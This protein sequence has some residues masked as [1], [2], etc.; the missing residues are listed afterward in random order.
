MSEATG[1]TVAYADILTDGSKQFLEHPAPF[2]TLGVG[3]RIVP[4]APIGGSCFSLY[5]LR[6]VT[7]VPLSSHAFL[8]F[9]FHLFPFSFIT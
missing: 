7:I 2:V 1:E 3:Y 6:S 8:Q 9:R 4:G 5:E